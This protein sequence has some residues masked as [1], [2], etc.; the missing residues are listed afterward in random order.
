MDKS[1]WYEGLLII[2]DDPVGYE[3]W[4]LSTATLPRL[5]R[6]K[7]LTF[8]HFYAPENKYLTTYY[9]DSINFTLT[10]HT[11]DVT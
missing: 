9:S 10:L 8:L 4:I 3:F 7:V 1:A 6:L 2:I 11:L 5:G